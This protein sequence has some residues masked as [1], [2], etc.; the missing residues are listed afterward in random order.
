MLRALK[1]IPSESTFL[2]LPV[3]PNKIE[4]RLS[5]EADEFV[6]G[7]RSEP[8]IVD[9]AILYSNTNKQSN[10]R[11]KCILLGLPE[12]NKIVAFSIIL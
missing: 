5:V 4:A 8:R 12:L 9:Y 11:S 1:M 6:Y 10:Q 3:V 7:G 2:E